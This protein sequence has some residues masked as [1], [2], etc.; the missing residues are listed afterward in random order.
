ML[1]RCAPPPGS[2]WSSGV[3]RPAVSRQP[4]PRPLHAICGPG[5]LA[6]LRSWLPAARVAPAG[7]PCP[8]PR[9]LPPS[10]HVL[11]TINDWYDREIDA[12]NEPYRPIPSGGRCRCGGKGGG[13]PPARRQLALSWPPAGA[14]VGTGQRRTRLLHAVRS[15]PPPAPAAACHPRRRHQRG[16]GDGAD[17]GAA[18]GRHRRGLPARPMGGQV[19]RAHALA[20][21]SLAGVA[22]K[23]AFGGGED[24]CECAPVAGAAGADGP[25]R[26]CVASRRMSRTASQSPPPI[27]LCRPQLPHHDRAGHLWLL[28]FLHLL[29]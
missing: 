10:L 16:G 2:P 7:G 1:P 5:Q 29:G 13:V 12:I 25:G 19:G 18:A 21:P 11:Q 8:L 15:T 22:C 3:A 23:E 27:P 6:P 20:Q 9:P 17:L 14:D 24:G 26:R 4:S 28:H